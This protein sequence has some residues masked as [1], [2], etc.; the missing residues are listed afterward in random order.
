MTTTMRLLCACAQLRRSDPLRIEY[1]PLL[2]ERLAEEG[3]GA[4]G[5]DSLPV[6]RAVL[7]PALA[8]GR[9]RGGL[10]VVPSFAPDEPRRLKLLP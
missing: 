7:R 9:A 8:G 1:Y 10:A 2:L 5:N 6:A 3:V 4:S